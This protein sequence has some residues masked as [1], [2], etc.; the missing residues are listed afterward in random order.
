[1]F[2]FYR[3]SRGEFQALI[4]IGA[5]ESAAAPKAAESATAESANDYTMKQRSVKQ[6]H[7]HSETGSIFSIMRHWRR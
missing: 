6:F 5:P 3:K 4:V 7:S 2:V 1:L